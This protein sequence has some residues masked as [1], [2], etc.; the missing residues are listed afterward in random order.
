MK[1]K[2]K[3]LK[4]SKDLPTLTDWCEGFAHKAALDLYQL[5]EEERNKV[6]ADNYKHLTAT[7]LAGFISALVFRSLA[8]MPEGIKSDKD[9][10]NYAME[11]FGDLKVRVQE[12]V[13][14]GFAGGMRTWSG[15]DV[16]YFCQVKVVPEPIN[17]EMC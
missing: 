5:F 12:A 6:G 11:S 13:A 16:D 7:F 17:K 9:K 8:Y 3:K 10:C 2:A 15:K 1:V 4:S 14:A